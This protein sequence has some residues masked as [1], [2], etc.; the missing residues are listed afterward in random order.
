MAYRDLVEFIGSWES[1][2]PKMKVLSK[3]IL[4]LL[5]VFLRKL[6]HTD[7][8]NVQPTDRPTDGQGGSKGSYTS[9]WKCKIGENI[10]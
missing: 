3:D 8:R 9:N 5:K 2:I 10:S 6:L 1:C 7:Q 4:K